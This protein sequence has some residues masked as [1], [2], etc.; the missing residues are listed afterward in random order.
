MIEPSTLSTR[1]FIMDYFTFEKYQHINGVCT[2]EEMITGSRYSYGDF[3]KFNGDVTEALRKSLF[4]LPELL[5]GS[6]YSG[7]TVNISNH[8]TFLEKFKDVEGVHNLYGGMGTYS[9]AIRLDVSEENEEIKDI[10]SSLEDYALIDEEDNSNLER[11]WEEEAIPDIIHD[12]S[13][14]LDLEPY[15]S[16]Y[17]GTDD[18]EVIT[19]LVGEGISALNLYWHYENTSAYLDYKVVMPYVTDCLLITHCIDLPL[20]INR[21]WSCKDTENKYKDKLNGI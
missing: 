3:E 7:G 14:H 9:V 5:T 12:V 6:D 21:V 20:L 17:D 11:T 10:L 19:E 4:I 18:I 13:R 16:D 1:N 8:R 15:V 2:P